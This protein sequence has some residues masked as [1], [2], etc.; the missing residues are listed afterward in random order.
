VVEDV[1]DL[2][3][4]RPVGLDEQLARGTL[5]QHLL[6]H[7]GD[8]GRGANSNPVSS[9]SRFPPPSPPFA[10]GR[11]L[12]PVGQRKGEGEDQSKIQLSF[13]W[14]AKTGSGSWVGATNQRDG[15]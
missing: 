4:E 6:R 3:V 10:F 11:R 5:H 12:F 1:A 7:R 8:G 13:L 2:E 15:A 14:A 9:S